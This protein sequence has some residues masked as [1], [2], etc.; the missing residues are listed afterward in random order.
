[1][2][3][4][5]PPQ[6]PKGFV[7][8]TKHKLSRPLSPEEAI[9]AMCYECTLQYSDGAKDCL[10]QSCPL[11]QHMPYNKTI[12]TDRDIYKSKYSLLKEVKRIKNH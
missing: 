7:E 1:M 12:E 10:I 9:L 5:K 8:F 3:E 4:N 6:K 11:H 2:P